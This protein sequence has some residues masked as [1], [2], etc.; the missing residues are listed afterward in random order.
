MPLHQIYHFGLFFAISFD[1]W[2]VD[3]IIRLKKGERFRTKTL[4][5]EKHV[6]FEYF[7]EHKQLE[8]F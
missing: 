7:M 2:L 6:L 4:K 5:T 1:I 8:L 3:K